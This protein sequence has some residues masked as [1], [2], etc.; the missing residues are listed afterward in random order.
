[1]SSATGFTI[2]S[3]YA[4]KHFLSVEDL[5][6]DAVLAIVERGRAFKA[7]ARP[8][9]GPDR[10]AI[11][12]FFEDSTRTMTSFQM[13]EH[14]LGMKVLDFDPKHSSVTKG[15]SLYDSVRTVD[16]IGADVAVIRHSRNAYYDQLLA[17]GR[18]ELS[19][20][21]AG[22]GSGQHPS[23]CMLD[24]MTIAEEFGH[25]DDLTIAIS[26][27]IAHSRVAR[28]DAQIL[29]R[30]GARVIFTGPREW[31]DHE[32]TRLGE[33]ST[34][35]EV[36]EDVDVAMM[37]RVQHERFDAGPDFS[38]ED[39]LH[40]YGLTDDRAARMRPDAIIMHPAPVN[41]GTEI[42]SKLVEAPQ[43]R[44]FAQMHN[45]VMVRMAILESVLDAAEQA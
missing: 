40:A 45:G 35:E 20:V 12:M 13:A 26:G 24:L 2:P 41:R 1:M 17:P 36:I 37:L 6:N 31:M 42:S 10:V 19:L 27:D 33:I 44:I 43:S 15:E 22:D 39:Y 21:N 8:R 14:R 25:F 28:S 16:A 29:N 4:S 9:L 30:L 32:V 34:L 5:P 11:N 38:A 7:G 23:Q 3:R 18:L